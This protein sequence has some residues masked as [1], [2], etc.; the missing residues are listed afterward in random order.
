MSIQRLVRDMQARS[1]EWPALGLVIRWAA[2]DPF[3]TTK[4]PA[5]DATT[6]GPL[7]E[8]EY[9]LVRLA[10]RAYSCPDETEFALCAL[11]AKQ[12]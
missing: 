2:V 12:A 8:R 10:L 4:H 9:A 7:T 11:E 6:A 5:P 3:Y 1:A